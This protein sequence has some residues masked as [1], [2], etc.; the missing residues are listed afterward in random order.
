MGKVARTD[1]RVELLKAPWRPGDGDYARKVNLA[2]RESAEPYLFLGADDLNFHEGWDTEALR[3]SDH[4]V[5]GTNDLHNPRV[6]AGRHSTHSLVSRRYADEYGI[7]D[8]PGILCEK[9]SHQWVDDELVAT[10]QARGEFHFCAESVVEHL[11]P[12]FGLAERDATYEKALAATRADGA[13]FRSR[14]RL[15]A[16][17]R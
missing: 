5:V 1:E 10:A 16:R 13:I 9:Y 12:F 3:F 15:W 4:G 7:I 8:G 6:L 14:R 11:H 17:G 2:Y